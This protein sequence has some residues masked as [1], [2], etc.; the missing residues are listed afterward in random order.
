ML[1]ILKKF[2]RNVYCAEY[3]TVTSHLCRLDIARSEKHIGFQDMA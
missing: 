2:M 3:A 1:Y